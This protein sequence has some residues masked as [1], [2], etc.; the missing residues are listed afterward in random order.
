MQNT[1][2][3]AYKK[4]LRTEGGGVGDPIA[5]SRKIYP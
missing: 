5:L 2:T 3:P 4:A 1:T